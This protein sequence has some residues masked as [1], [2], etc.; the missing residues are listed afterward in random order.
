M[1]LLPSFLFA[2]SANIDSFT[3][4]ISY[5][6]KKMKISPL[7]T[8]LI[9]LIATAGTFLSMVLGKFLIKFMSENIANV[10]GSGFLILLGIWFI[11]DAV[12]KEHCNENKKLCNA[13]NNILPYKNLLENPEIADVDNSGYIDVKESIF[14]AFALTINNV[15]VGIGASITGINILLATIFT[16]ILSTTGLVSGCVIGSSCL[17]KFFGKYAP[18]VSG[19]SII[20]LGIYELLI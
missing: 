5:G 12:I 17:S 20:I 9:A 19:I 2:L 6:I 1:H 11:I 18:F 8:I 3:V 14:L 10:I 7:S 15:G 13:E 16:F 4:G